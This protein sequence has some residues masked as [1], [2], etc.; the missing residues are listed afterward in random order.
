MSNN[1]H[2]PGLSFTEFFRAF[3]EFRR[4]PLGFMFALTHRHGHVVR[5][6]G[7][8]VTHQITHPLDVERVL[9]TNAQ[10]Y[11]KGRSFRRLRPISGNGLLFSDGELWRRQR[12]LVQPAFQRQRLGAYAPAIT[13]ATAALVT[14]WRAY[15]A[16][17]E[18][19]DVLHEMMRLA[20]D[21]I[22]QT[23]FG[24]DLSGDI[25][26]ISRS[27]DVV[28]AF[29]IKRLWQ[30]FPRP[31]S[32]PTR[33]NREFQRAV[34]AAD[35]VILDMIAA[36]RAGTVNSDDLLSRLVN[37]TDAETGA[38]MDDEQLRAEVVTFLTAG[39]E[40]TAVALTWLWYLLAQN[41][42]AE[43]RLRAELRRVLDGRTPALADLPQ[44]NY[45]LMCIEE[46]MRLYPPV[47]VTGRT[48]LGADT[49]GGYAIAPNSELLLS[50]YITHRHPDF[51]DEPDVFNP[52]RFTPEQI[53]ARPRYAYY[54]FGGGPRQCVGNNFAL[55]EM[56]L[57]VAA[58]AQRFRLRLV[59][60]HK[61][62]A[63]PSI[64]L[65]P[66]NGVRVTLHEIEN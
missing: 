60:T 56:L 21:I 29:S 23:I 40:S 57:V 55:L 35:H 13:R 19:F 34:G 48:A 18:A 4:D 51:W 39:H 14:R 44:L 61:V 65:R 45:T 15:A 54:P 16:S 59:P 22:G 27:I 10:N 66:R 33:D 30:V 24:T 41:E 17:G 53:A 32:L 52:E 42:A 6:R 28:R 11:R 37:A 26:T 1:H 47:W 58:I 46:A 8:W 20:L 63:D 9:Q 64:T 2:A 3:P 5:F 7:A 49:L 50:A 31:L 36:R 38:K 62:E 12:R 43:E 25:E